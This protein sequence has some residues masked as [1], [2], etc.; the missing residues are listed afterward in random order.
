[1]CCVCEEN[2]DIVENSN[3][4]KTLIVYTVFLVV[5]GTFFLYFREKKHM[6]TR[7]LVLYNF[8]IDKYETTH[9]H[10]RMQL[11]VYYM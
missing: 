8:F 5:Y 10:T 11:Y 7:N 9:T 6:S 3:T 2:V 4:H 1:M